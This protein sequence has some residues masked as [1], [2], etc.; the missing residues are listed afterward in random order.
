M[1]SKGR[2]IKNIVDAHCHLHEFQ[3]V[4]IEKIVR[5]YTII[6]VSDDYPSSIRTLELAS[7]YS[8]VV[9]CVGIHPW[10]VD[11]IDRDEVDKIRK[12]ACEAMCI[13]EVG[14]DTKFVPETIERQREIFHEMLKIAKELSLPVNLHCAGTWREVYDLV[15]K[16]DVDRANFHWYTGPLELLD[17]IVE[18]GFYVSINPAV[19]IQRKHQEVVRRLPLE[20]MLLE[21]DGPYEYRGIR[22]EPF[23]IRET[24]DMVSRIKSVDPSRVIEICR[25]NAKRFLKI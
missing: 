17:E 10:M 1:S 9:P 16:Y 14:L 23:L 3:D 15:L 20:N 13:G 4:T 22:M 12:I 24:I 25:E 18:K 5:E 6:A 7:K 11:K 2:E 19:K 8:S 21:S